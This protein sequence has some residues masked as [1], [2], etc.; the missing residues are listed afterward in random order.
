MTITIKTNAGAAFVR[1][2]KVRGA[3]VIAGPVA[4]YTSAR[5]CVPFHWNVDVMTPLI[6]PW[7]SKVMRKAENKR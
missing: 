2:A 4:L 1:I 6:V 3:P 5:A 7:D